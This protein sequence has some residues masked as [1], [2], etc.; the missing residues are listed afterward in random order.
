M[1]KLERGDKMNKAIERA[2]AVRPFVKWLGERTYTVSSSDGQRVYIVRFVVANGHKLAECNCKAGE[3][4]MLCYH[5]AAAAAV[6]IAVA[7]IHRQAE[8]SAAPVIETK[9]VTTSNVRFVSNG[10]LSGWYY[11]SVMI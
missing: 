1:I 8:Q 4:G 11:G 7:S 5:V 6:N 10:Q 3:A 2:K 9:P